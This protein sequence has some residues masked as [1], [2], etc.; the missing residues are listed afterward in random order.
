MSTI[1]LTVK[2]HFSAGHR[3]PGLAGLGAKCEHLH[4][5]TFG[6]AW[7]F[8]VSGLDAAEFEFAEA[9]KLLRG[10]V[11]EHLDHGYL[12]APDDAE[13][14]EVLR[15]HGWKHYIVAP[16]PT[17]EAIAGLLLRQACQTISAP[18][19]AVCLTEGPHNAATVTP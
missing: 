14:L 11:D 18:C 8:R 4:G 17:T 5:H 6:V 9:K 15:A 16:L 12:V 19:M 2:H 7:T 10:W 3:I 13:L 1:E